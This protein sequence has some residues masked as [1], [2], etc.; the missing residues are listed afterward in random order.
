MVTGSLFEP[1]VPGGFQYRENFITVEEEDRLASEIARVEFSTFEMRVVAVPRSKD[2]PV[3][4][5][6]DACGRTVTRSGVAHGL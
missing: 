2:R 4:L 3:Q 1:D 6:G 5:V